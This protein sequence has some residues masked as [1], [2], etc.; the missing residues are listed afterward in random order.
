MRPYSIAVAP[1]S[2]FLKRFKSLDI[3]LFPCCPVVTTRKLPPI[4]S[5]PVKEVG[6]RPL[7]LGEVNR[8]L[9]TEKILS[10]LPA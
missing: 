6:K 4:T 10:E 9:A 8:A 5:N 1:L 7:T 3:G 2:S